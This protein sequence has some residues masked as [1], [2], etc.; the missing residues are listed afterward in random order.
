MIAPHTLASWILVY[1]SERDLARRTRLHYVSCVRRYE[2]WHGHPMA[3]QLA[4]DRINEYLEHLSDGRNRYTAHS[5]RCG[6]LTLLNAAAAEGLCHLPRKVR[7]IRR[8]EHRPR[9]WQPEELAAL[10]QH[11]SPIQG[12]AI[13]LGYDTGLRRS[14]LFAVR[15][16]QVIGR[17]DDWRIVHTAS[18]TGRQVVRRIR[19]ETWEACDSLRNPDD[20][21]LL[22]S[23]VKLTGWRR[24]WHK[25]G[26][27]AGIDTKGRG[28][29]ALRRTGASL[30]KRAGANP[31]EYLGHSPRSGDLAS[32]YYLD[33][34][35][36]DSA[37]PLPPRW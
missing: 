3:L 26:T 22:P 6:L 4:C 25:L 10:M 19:N 15:W 30:T 31:G 36:L 35:L 17:R 5:Q 8:P 23:D 9:G 37:P 7:P 2:A 18:K 32:R 1:T 13:R 34:E 14:D 27:I 24:R 20:D 21:R 16:P 33:P 11:A 12:A 28:L 29:Q